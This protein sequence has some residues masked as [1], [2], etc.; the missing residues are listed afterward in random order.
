MSQ[1]EIRIGIGVDKGMNLLPLAG[2]VDGESRPGFRV[3]AAFP[4]PFV[5]Q[6]FHSVGSHLQ[7]DGAWRQISC[8]Q[9]KGNGAASVSGS[10]SSTPSSQLRDRIWLWLSVRAYFFAYF[11]LKSRARPA[12]AVFLLLFL[13]T[14]QAMQTGLA[15][16]RIVDLRMV[17]PYGIL[18]GYMEMGMLLAK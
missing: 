17:K 9:G 2:Q 12:G 18:Y 5:W 1:V 8:K 3:N 13:D 4:S 11:G 7:L 6:G 14:A 15:L 16:H 10:S